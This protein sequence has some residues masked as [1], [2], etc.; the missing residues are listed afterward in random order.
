MLPSLATFGFGWSFSVCTMSKQTGKQVA[1][2]IEVNKP[3]TFDGVAI[4]QASFG[5]GG[6]GLSLRAWD[7]LGRKSSAA[8]ML[9][10]VNQALIVWL[11]YAAWLHLRMQKGLRGPALAWWSILG[12]LVTTFAF[13]GVNMFLSGL[14]SYGQL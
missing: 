5:D 6:T 2:T 11:N 7:L 10:R 14:H 13:L 8:E 3:L 1:A 12:L 4:Y 9:G